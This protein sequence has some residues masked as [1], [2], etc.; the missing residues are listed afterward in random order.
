MLLSALSSGE[1]SN[2]KRKS[3]S[4]KWADNKPENKEEIATV[5]VDKLLPPAR[6]EQI[7]SHKKISQKSI[8]PIMKSLQADSKVSFALI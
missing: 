1:A 8:K 5:I 7:V 3:A 6:I 4:V 2:K